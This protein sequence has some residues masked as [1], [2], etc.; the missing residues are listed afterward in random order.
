MGAVRHRDGG[1]GYEG[2]TLCCDVGALC[3]VK[4]LM[5]AHPVQRG[6]V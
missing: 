6:S 2:S 1:C 4:V 3:V 5:E